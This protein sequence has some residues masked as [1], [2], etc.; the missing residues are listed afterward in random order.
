[1]NF[2]QP[3]SGHTGLVSDLNGSFGSWS[4]GSQRRGG[5]LTAEARVPSRNPVRAYWRRRPGGF[6]RSLDYGDVTTRCRR[7]RRTRVRGILPRLHPDAEESDGWRC[8]RRLWASGCDGEVVWLQIG[9][10][11]RDQEMCVNVAK[12]IQEMGRSRAHRR[13]RIS[14][15][16]PADWRSSGEKCRSP[17]C[18]SSGEAKGER[19]RTPGASY[20]R[21]RGVELSR[22]WR[23]L[24]G[25]GSYCSG[26]VTGGRN[27]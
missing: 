22:Q 4:D 3:R 24:K 21:G 20:R 7:A 2:G 12:R 19:E 17:C 9:S 16:R 6:W 25:G 11:Q 27:G 10:C 15:G 18:G 14:L 5:Q 26:L 8:R 23:E 13:G 1:M